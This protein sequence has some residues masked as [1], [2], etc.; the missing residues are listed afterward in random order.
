MLARMAVLCA[1]LLISMIP[2]KAGS[3]GVGEMCG[4]TPLVGPSFS[5]VVPEPVGGTSSV[6]LTPEVPFVS[7]DF[8]FA[9]SS[10]APLTCDST[11]FSSCSVSEAGG[12]A[13]VSFRGGQGIPAGVDFSIVLQGFTAGQTI[14]GLANVPEPDTLLLAALALLAISFVERARLRRTHGKP[15]SGADR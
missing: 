2:L 5:F 1:L 12:I 14:S 6:C 4:G 10:T 9:S 7:L 11:V 8:V 15:V 13:D 3:I